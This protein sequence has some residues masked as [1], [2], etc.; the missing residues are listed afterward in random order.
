[1]LQKT[2]INLIMQPCPQCLS[3][4]NTTHSLCHSECFQTASAVLCLIVTAHIYCVYTINTKK[5]LNIY[6]WVQLRFYCQCLLFSLLQNTLII[7]FCLWYPILHNCQIHN[8]NI[9][10]Y[11]WYNKTQFFYLEINKIKHRDYKTF[12]KTSGY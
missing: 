7:I 11:N 5:H 6:T 9:I 12:S 4:L 8:H 1:M 2:I 10:P 3:C